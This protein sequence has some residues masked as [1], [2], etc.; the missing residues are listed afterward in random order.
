MT[1]ADIRATVAEFATTAR[2]A[3][4]AGFAGV[5]VHSANGHLLHQ[6]LPADHIPADGGLAAAGRL[7]TEG[8]DLTALGRP[9]LAN[10][11]LV[12]R[13]RTGAPVNQVRNRHL[14]YVGG[15][16]GY[17]DYPALPSGPSAPSAVSA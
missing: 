5:E 14:M 12:E 15:E 17:T 4:D 10:P 9:F 16:T 8:A 7:L 13:L 6:F 2:R 11:D 1:G 3:V